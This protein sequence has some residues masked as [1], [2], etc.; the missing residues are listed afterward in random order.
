MGCD[1]GGNGDGHNSCDDEESM[2]VKE[3]IYWSA[4]IRISLY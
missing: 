2:H 1:S 3:K 4:Q